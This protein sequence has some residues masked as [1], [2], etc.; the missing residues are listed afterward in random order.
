M[1]GMLIVVTPL[2][3]VLLV[4]VSA[5]LGHRHGRHLMATKW[6]KLLAA[7]AAKRKA[8]S[9]QVSQLQQQVSDL[10]GELNG[11]PDA[12]DEAAFTAETNALGLDANGDPVVN[13]PPPPAPDTV[14]AGS[15][16]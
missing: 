3:A 15:G 7:E 13:A 14:T 9:D 5:A 10:E 11:V 2:I 16:Q 4:L 8:L 6:S 12:D 1:S